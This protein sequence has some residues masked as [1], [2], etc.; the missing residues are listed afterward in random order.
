[1]QIKNGVRTVESLSLDDL[2]V[3]LNEIKIEAAESEVKRQR[4]RSAASNACSY[5]V[6]C[7]VSKIS[8]GNLLSVVNLEKLM[9]NRII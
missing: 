3:F 1:M 5:Q 7:H 8:S 9:K 4:R 2:M 6:H